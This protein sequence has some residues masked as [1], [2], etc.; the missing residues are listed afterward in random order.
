MELP[1]TNVENKKVGIDMPTINGHQE[2]TS[3]RVSRNYQEYLALSIAG[4]AVLGVLVYQV[5]KKS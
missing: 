5:S 1:S 3:Q 4:I 2:D